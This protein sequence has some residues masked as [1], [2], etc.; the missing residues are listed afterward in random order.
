M[1]ENKDGKISEVEWGDDM[2][3]EGAEPESGGFEAIDANKDGHIDMDEFSHHESGN[4][5]VEYAM[6]KLLELADKDGDGHF[7]SAE[8]EKVTEE[9]EGHAA[10]PPNLDWVFHD[11]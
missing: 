3:S 5:H 7:S 4:H 6:K 2:R 10:H 8:L 1:D 11:E 9:R